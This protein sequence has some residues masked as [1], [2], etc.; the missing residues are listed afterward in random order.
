MISAQVPTLY[1]DSSFSRR[2]FDIA[3]YL[4]ASL[5]PGFTGSPM[6]NLAKI[7]YFTRIEDEL[8]RETR[9]ELATL[10]LGSRCSTTELLPPN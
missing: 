5:N 8:E 6:V 4:L 1:R 9:L 3:H 10:C 2:R 7:V